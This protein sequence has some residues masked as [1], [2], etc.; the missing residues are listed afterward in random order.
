MIKYIL[1]SLIAI[2]VS[3][4]AFAREMT[5]PIVSVTDGD[6]IRSYLKLPCPLCSVSVRIL[7]IDT[8]ESTYL[9]KCKKEKELALQATQFVKSLVSGHEYM[10]IYNFRWDKYGGRINAIVVVNGVDIGQELINRGLAVPYSGRGPR[11]DWC[12]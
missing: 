2:T 10:Q 3:F 11:H 9:A 6:T 4:T 5:L 8:P 1:V 7:G 12:S